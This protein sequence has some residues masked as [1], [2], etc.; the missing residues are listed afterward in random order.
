VFDEPTW[1]WMRKDL[2]RNKDRP[3]LFMMHESIAPPSFLGADRMRKMLEEHPN[4][5]AAFCGHLHADVQFRSGGLTYLVCP[6]LGPNPR[7]GFKIVKVYREAL[8]LRTVEYD[9]ENQQFEKVMKW[10]RVDIPESL[11]A[12]VHRPLDREFKK[13][14]YSEVPPHPRR[15]DPQLIERSLELIGPLMRFLGERVMSTEP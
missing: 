8:I 1:D 4:V 5:I 14:N 6:G 2:Q 10:Q 13:R 15:N 7:H 11:Q 3:A 9:A 12:S